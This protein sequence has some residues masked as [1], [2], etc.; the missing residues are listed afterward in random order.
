MKKEWFSIPDTAKALKIGPNRVR[1]AL[2]AG[3]IPDTAIRKKGKRIQVH[4][5]RGRFAYEGNTDQ[6]RSND[7][8]RTGKPA[9]I[10]KPVGR[11]KPVLKPASK[12]TQPINPE[13]NQPY[14]LTEVKILRELE[15]I[16]TAQLDREIK[17]G[18]WIPRK[19]GERLFE[20][21][22]TNLKTQLLGIKSRMAPIIKE[23]FADDPHRIKKLFEIIDAISREALFTLAGV[24]PKLDTKYP[25]PQNKDTKEARSNGNKKIEGKSAHSRSG[26]GSKLQ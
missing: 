20:Q 13:T 16:Q 5:E 11:K 19:W 18:Y 4:L 17:Q 14:T 3:I 26:K 23:H 7:G 2:R 10:K 21:S 6:T 1:Y 24:K 12:K 9:A 25:E 22:F 15:Q 8:N